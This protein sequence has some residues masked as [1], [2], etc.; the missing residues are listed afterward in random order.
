MLG[1]HYGIWSHNGQG[2]PTVKKPKEQHSKI[3]SHIGYG[4]T[5]VA[6]LL[7]LL[8]FL[9][10]QFCSALISAHFANSGNH[11]QGSTLK[12]LRKTSINP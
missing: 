4:N 6:K 12:T 11:S 5:A 3:I 8:L 1:V 7:L 10:A 2:I 9:K